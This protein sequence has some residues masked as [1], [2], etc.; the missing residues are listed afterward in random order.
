NTILV[1]HGIGNVEDYHLPPSGSQELKMAVEIENTDG[2]KTWCSF[3][4]KT[5]R[6][7]HVQCALGVS[8]QRLGVIVT[9]TPRPK[10]CSG[11]RADVP[12]NLTTQASSVILE[13]VNDQ[14]RCDQYVS[15]LDLATRRKLKKPNLE[16]RVR[17]VSPTNIPV[18]P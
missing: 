1:G 16:F 5:E 8:S 18:Y 3:S 12:E 4:E 7:V 11:F 17:F 14:S 13:S 15:L 6:E 9:V 10:R 2:M